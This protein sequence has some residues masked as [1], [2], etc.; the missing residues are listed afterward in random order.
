MRNE[1]E[2]L[3]NIADGI[4][5]FDSGRVA[6]GVGE[7]LNQGLPIDLI[8]REGLGKGMEEVGGKYEKGE[9]FLSE[10]IMSGIVMNEAM[11]RLK[12]ILKSKRREGTILIGTVE[13]D[14]HDIGKNLVKYMLESAGYDIVDLG[15]DVTPQRFV[16]KIRETRPHMVCVS[17]LLSVTI[18]KVK[19]TIRVLREADQGG[20]LKILV[21]GRSLS[22]EIAREMGADAYGKDCWD[23]LKKA[24]DLL[25]FTLAK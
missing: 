13:G 23:G 25:Y 22:D 11:E 24:K 18:P 9:Y 4:L 6:K 21:G 17:A 10:L 12:P 7:A 16:E 3:D 15:V 19:E 5:L 1:K 2:I 20:A 8:V 14:L